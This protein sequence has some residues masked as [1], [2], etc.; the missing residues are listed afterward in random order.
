MG[1]LTK[2]HMLNLGECLHKNYESV[3]FKDFFKRIKAKSV[4]LG[5]R[6]HEE[7]AKFVIASIPCVG[8]LISSPVH[9]ITV[10][11]VGEEGVG[12]KGRVHVP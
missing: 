3:N 8:G 1:K 10:S 9:R 2:W 11:V 12:G 6:M 5:E 7:R 4:G